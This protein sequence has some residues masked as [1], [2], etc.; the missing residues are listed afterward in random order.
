MTIRL[1][2]IGVGSRGRHWLDIVSGHPAFST[3][4]CVDADPQALRQACSMPNTAKGRA[5]SDLDQALADAKAEAALVASPSFLHA[6]H[7]I[8]ALDAGLAVMV[9]K[10]LGCDLKEAVQVVAKAAETGRPLMVAENYRFFQAE[11]TV[12]HL[13]ERE[14]AGTLGSAICIDRRNQPSSTQGP[15]VK[16][17]ENPFL[18]EIAVHHFDSFRYLF[19]RRPASIF[20]TAYNPAGSDYKQ[21]GAIEALIELDDRFPIQYAGTFVANRY[22]YSLWIE[23]ERGEI[24]TDRRSVWWRS[25]GEQ[26]FRSVKPVPVPLGDELPYPKSG[27]TSLLNQFRE[28]IEQGQV[29]ETSGRD[30][31]WTLAMLEAGILSDKRKQKVQI[32]EVYTPQ[33]RSWAGVLTP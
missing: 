2:H 1:V 6:A 9:E 17:M 30:N 5:F 27:T 20:A 18:T 32:D 15:W 10:P 7:A 24:R 31:L 23:G 11:R 29:P 33:L 14:V 13:L 3:V 26:T 21:Q 16:N 8:R 12:R 25:K 19:N 22:E 28:A 4:A